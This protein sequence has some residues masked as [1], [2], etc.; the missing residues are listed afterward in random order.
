MKK[1]KFDV[2]NT[3]LVLI[4]INILLHYLIPI[5]QIIFNFWIYFG[6]VLF[7]IGWIP[8][9]WLGIYFRKINTSIPAKDKPKKLVTT[10]LFRFSRNP[11]YLGM[12]IALV[13]EAIFLGSLITF[14][15]PIFF[16]I[17]INVLNISFEEEILE[18]TFGHKYLKYKKKVRRWI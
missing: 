8:N 12:V 10:G 15:I 2:A 16:F 6:A 1:L 18:K 7:V 3:F 4:I 11:N 14:F 13:G 17:A 5:K 9:F